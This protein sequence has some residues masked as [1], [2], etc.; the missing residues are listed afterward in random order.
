MF[1]IG[2]LVAPDLVL[3]CAHIIHY[4]LMDDPSIRS[5]AI[6][7]KFILNFEEY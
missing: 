1:E 6:K 4:R 2:T 7:V 5:T 3:V